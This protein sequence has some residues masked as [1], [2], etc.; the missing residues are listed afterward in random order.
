V[1]YSDGD[2]VNHRSSVTLVVKNSAHN[3]HS[4]ALLCWILVLVLLLSII[5]SI[6]VVICVC[7]RA[8]RTR[9]K[10]EQQHRIATHINAFSPSLTT[11]PSRQPSIEMLPKYVPSPAQS[12]SKLYQWCQQRELQQQYKSLWAVNPNNDTGNDLHLLH[13]TAIY[14]QTLQYF[15]QKPLIQ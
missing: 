6:V 4:L 13:I 5:V 7:L 11:I 15:K 12:Y 3:N 8:K 2:F 14:W 1:H 9:S 10:Q